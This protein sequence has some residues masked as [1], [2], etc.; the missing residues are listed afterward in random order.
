MKITISKIL[1]GGIDLQTMEEEPKSVLLECGPRS[2]SMGISDEQFQIILHLLGTGQS[3]NE[4][5][6]E[7]IEPPEPPQMAVVHEI[8]Q[9]PSE[10]RALGETY[11]VSY[12][13]PE[14]GIAAF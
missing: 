13:D 1:E 8:P 11:D 14:T 12:D 10:D 5:M 3:V 9:V 4:Q 2:A 7:S 6:T